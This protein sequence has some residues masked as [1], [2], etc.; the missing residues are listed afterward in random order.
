MQSD[1]LCSYSRV[2]AMSE[3]K[4]DHQWGHLAFVPWR[5]NRTDGNKYK[6]MYI[7]VFT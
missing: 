6:C 2:E 3:G 7:H 4:I 5:L 1:T